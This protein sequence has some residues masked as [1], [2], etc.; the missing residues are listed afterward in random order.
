MGEQVLTT[1]LSVGVSTK[2]ALVAFAVGVREIKYPFISIINHN[3]LL[4]EYCTL[5]N[6]ND[7]Y[8]YCGSLTLLIHLP[9]TH[10]SRCR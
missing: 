5:P 2:E 4:V 3:T 9:V 7:C 10:S 6:Y 8:I 1:R